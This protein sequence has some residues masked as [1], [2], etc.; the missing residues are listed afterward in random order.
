MVVVREH[1]GSALPSCYKRGRRDFDGTGRRE[2]WWYAIWPLCY[3]LRFEAWLDDLHW[4]ASYWLV[5]KGLLI[6]PYEGCYLNELE[7]RWP[8][9]W[10]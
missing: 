6:E 5:D 3:L 7:W 9:V 4:D 8:Q 2:T 10:K 1:I